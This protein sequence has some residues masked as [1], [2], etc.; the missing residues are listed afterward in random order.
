MI[1]LALIAM[2]LTAT[3]VQAQSWD[4]ATKGEGLKLKGVAHV[5]SVPGKPVAAGEMSD[6]KDDGGVVHVTDADFDAEVAKSKL[7]VLVDFWAPWC[8]PCKIIGPVM[9]RIAKEYAGKVKIVKYNV[10]DSNKKAKEL[11]I[12]G[13]PTVIA[14]KGGKEVDRFSGIPSRD[15]EVIRE[16]LAKYIKDK[17][18][19]DDPVKK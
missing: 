1:R 16:H 4:S 8:P 3:G 6:K 18:G 11:G 7:P 9:D 2:A 17:L 13:I 15:E 14:F 5:P 12:Q 10:D 19:V